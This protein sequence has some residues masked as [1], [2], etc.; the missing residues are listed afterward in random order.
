MRH[1]ALEEK[2]YSLG[3]ATSLPCPGV[4]PPRL[5]G[6]PRAHC[7]DPQGSRRQVINACERYGV[8]EEEQEE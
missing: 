8:G 2:P 5:A 4:C 3:A 6:P 1:V 7:L